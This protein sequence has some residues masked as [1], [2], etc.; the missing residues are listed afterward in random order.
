MKPFDFV[1]DASYDK[2]NLMVGSE[3]DEL[4]EKAYSP[5]LTNMA[6]SYHPDSILH[7]NL[8]NQ[9]HHLDHRPQ[10]V[11]YINSLRAKKRFA[12]WHKKETDEDLDL[13]CQTYDVNVNVAR[14]YL[15]LLTQ[16]QLDLMRKK[17]EK[18]GKHE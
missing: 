3:N 11:F 15:S 18:G 9:Y 7:A 1:S 14:E 13:V 5:W 17:Q 12:K 16:E 6:F 8:M 4:A 10:Y 2:K